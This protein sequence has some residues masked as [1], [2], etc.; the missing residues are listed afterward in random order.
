[1]P[2]SEPLL[3]AEKI[4]VPGSIWASHWVRCTVADCHYVTPGSGSE[5]EAWAAHARHA[6]R[7]HR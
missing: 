2:S 5:A 1:M 6:E 7:S 4:H 3:S